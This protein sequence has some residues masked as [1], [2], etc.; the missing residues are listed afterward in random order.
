MAELAK[1]YVQIIPSAK[2]MHGSIAKELGGE[3]STA[4]KSAGSSIASGIR[5]A[6][7]AAG[8]GKLLK[9]TISEG[10]EQSIG[11][12]E[13][14][15]KDSADKVMQ[16]AKNAYKTAGMSANEYM[17]LTTSFSAS[18]LQSLA[19]DTA[20]AADVADMAMTDM[21][22]NA[23]K[24]GTD[25]ESIKNAY[26]GFAKQNYTMLDNL[27]LGY[28]GT[29]TEMERLLAD[30]QKIS[31]VEYNI[32]NLSDVYNAIHIIQG[33]LDITGTTAKE[34]A[35]TISGS[36]NSMKSAF[37]NVLGNLALGED[38][39]PS[40]QALGETVTT[41]LTGNLIP[42]VGNILTSIPSLINGIVPIILKNI[43]IASN[44]AD[45]I[46]K[47]GIGIVTEIIAGIITSLPYVAEAAINLITSFGSALINTDW[48][49]IAKE[50]I[51]E[52]RDGIGLAAGEI[53][54]EDE[55]IIGSVINAINTNLPRIINEG[56]EIATNIADGMLQKIP[57]VIEIA[58]GMIDGFIS[59]IVPMIPTILQT[60]VDLITNL[61]DGI[62]QKLPDV[63]TIAGELI[64]GFVSG[65][66]PMLPTILQEGAN[67]IINLV[68]GIIQ[69]LPNIIAAASE[70]IFKFISSIGQKLPQII[71]SG[72]G[73][74]V[75]LAA[76]LIKAIPTIVSKIPQIVRSIIDKFMET[77][78]LS[79]GANIIEGIANGLANAA[80]ML[81]DAAKEALGSFKDQV[82]SFFGIHSPSTWGIWVGEMLDTGVAN[83]VSKGTGIVRK[84]V[85]DLITTLS[86][87]IT[88]SINY[89]VT[90]EM[91]TGS[92]YEGDN[93]TSRLDLIISLIRAMLENSGNNIIQINGREIGRVLRG[94]GVVFE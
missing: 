57:D 44:N 30:A 73:I 13:T 67:L 94:M 23:N 59:G 79:I 63:I 46:V 69:N 83:G 22:D 49:G 7:I 11:G 72:I 17:Q 51:A 74:I 54:G 81:W 86:S 12:I 10:A 60:G 78:W 87:P 37:K 62:L 9:E 50:M 31:G 18:L 71:Q 20:K 52:I 35:S 48:T 61:L 33:E 56:V 85:D 25:M 68:N 70:T 41:F 4:G 47:Q 3:A 38:I 32:D 19:N 88:S 80:G 40:L 15:F 24:M 65:I 58:G 82:L 89:Q 77:D 43:N 36:M 39:G 8:I 29:K 93:Y 1:A 16:N 53:L 91:R 34:A 66:L 14:L 5:N 64:T 84:S 21:S 55:D 92:R 90:G 42:A 27:K 28:G 76:G 26:Q 45:E 2:G 6:I 75:N